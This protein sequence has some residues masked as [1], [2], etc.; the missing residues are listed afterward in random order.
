MARVYFFHTICNANGKSSRQNK[1][2]SWETDRAAGPERKAAGLHRPT[3]TWRHNSGDSAG[4]TVGERDA[5]PW[6]LVCQ[7]WASQSSSIV[8]LLETH[9]PCAT[10]WSPITKPRADGPRP[11]LHGASGPAPRSVY[12]SVFRD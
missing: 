8:A 10:D 6:H 4:K 11:G 5:Q 7:G 9:T 1:H 2:C 12:V 3:S